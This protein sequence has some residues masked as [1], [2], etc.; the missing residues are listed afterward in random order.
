[1]PCSR[2]CV[3]KLV[4]LL[5]CTLLLCV[6][7]YLTPP[8]ICVDWHQSAFPHYGCCW[9][10]AHEPAANKVKVWIISRQS[11]W[12]NCVTVWESYQRCWRQKKWNSWCHFSWWN[13][14]NA[15]GRCDHFLSVMNSIF[16][17]C[18]FKSLF[19]ACLD[20]L[21][22][23]L[24]TLTRQWPLVL[25]FKVVYWLGMWLMCYCWT[26]LPCLWV[27]RLWGACSLSWSTETPP[28]PVKKAR[29]E[30]RNKWLKLILWTKL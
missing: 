7:N 28:S 18:R 13:V 14:K 23:V 12:A 5:H 26:W 16:R 9:T 6:P 21:L 30:D 17:P 22:V 11:H 4:Q 3:P 25:L 10:K 27:L 8:P 2:N 20:V 15:K 24:W 29:W 1:M 19:G